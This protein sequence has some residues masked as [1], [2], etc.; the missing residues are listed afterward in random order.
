MG[1]AVRRRIEGRLF[2][3]L[4]CLDFLGNVETFGGMFRAFGM[5]RHFGGCLDLFWH[6][7]TFLG[8][9]MNS[10]ECLDLKPTC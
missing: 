4:Y 8:N 10:S 9:V 5:F 3:F 7:G 1:G 6:V 2:I